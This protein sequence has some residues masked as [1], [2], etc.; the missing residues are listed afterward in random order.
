MLNENTI[1]PS[2]ILVAE[3]DRVMSDVIAF[4]LQRSGYRVTVARTGTDAW[5][6]LSSNRFDVLITDYQMPG[7][8]GEELCRSLRTSQPDSQM[9]II[10]LSARSLELDVKRMKEELGIVMVL[11]KPFSPRELVQAT[12]N[13]LMTADTSATA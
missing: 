6:Q 9:P 13:C 4:N 12:R 11:H 7:M 5:E 8:T 10:L 3:D 1:S 2:S